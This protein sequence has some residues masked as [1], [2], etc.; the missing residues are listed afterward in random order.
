MSQAAHRLRLQ[1]I[2]REIPFWGIAVLMV[3][4]CGINGGS[5]GK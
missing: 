1:N 2:D 3:I 4:F 5:L